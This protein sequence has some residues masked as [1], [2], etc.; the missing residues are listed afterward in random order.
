MSRCIRM[1]RRLVLAKHLTKTLSVP[2]SEL[3]KHVKTIVFPFNVEFKR[4]SLICLY[5]SI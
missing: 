5:R 3:K 4:K 1:F 2:I